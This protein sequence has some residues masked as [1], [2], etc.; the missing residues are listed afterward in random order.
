M[1]MNCPTCHAEIE[2][3]QQPPMKVMNLISTSVIICEHPDHIV[4]PG[5][6]AVLTH[7]V[8]SAKVAT[9]LSVVPATE[10]KSVIVSPNGG[11]VMRGDSQ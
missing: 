9:A 5:C 11:P 4:C 6:Q 1:K 10:Q 7:A 3:G 2:V 8:V